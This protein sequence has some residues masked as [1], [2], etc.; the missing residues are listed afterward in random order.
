MKEFVAMLHVSNDRLLQTQVMSLLDEQGLRHE[1]VKH[2]ESTVRKLFPSST[3]C[4]LFGS[5]VSGNATDLSDTDVIVISPGLSDLVR[6]EIYCDGLILDVHKHSVETIGGKLDK[7]LSSRLAFYTSIVAD[8]SN[9]LVIF[10][11]CDDFEPLRMRAIA[12]LSDPPPI[13]NWDNFRSRIDFEILDLPRQRHW[14]ERQLVL[15]SIYS[16]LLLVLSLLHKGW[17]ARVDMMRSWLQALA[18]CE[19]Q[20]LELAYQEALYGKLQC[21]ADVAES[22]LLHIGGPK[23]PSV[24]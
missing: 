14:I 7:E 9:S 4:L 1:L 20:R 8:R 13:T 10:D 15:A 24:R 5:L 6:E 12:S 16:Q 2:I 3:A 11:D 21:I 18:P 19:L 17:V 22:V 23:H